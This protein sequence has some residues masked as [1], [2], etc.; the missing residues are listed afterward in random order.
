MMIGN[1]VNEIIEAIN[2]HFDDNKDIAVDC[3]RYIAEKTADDDLANAML[4][5]VAEMGYCPIC[6]EKKSVFHNDDGGIV[7]CRRCDFGEED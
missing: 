6:G 4:D 7:L 1:M 5:R 3:F 2:V